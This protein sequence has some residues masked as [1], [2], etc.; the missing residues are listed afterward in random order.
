M[1]KRVHHIS[2]LNMELT[3]EQIA[4]K[5]LKVFDNHNRFEIR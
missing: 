5:G 2:K 3:K 1:C 4:K